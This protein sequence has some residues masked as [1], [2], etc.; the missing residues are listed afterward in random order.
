MYP[1]PAESGTQR[2]SNFLITFV[3]Y[4]DQLSKA[5][6]LSVKSSELLRKLQAA[7]WA[8]DKNRGKGS[9]LVLRHPEHAEPII[10]PSHGS[11]EMATGT[12]AHILKKAGLK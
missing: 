2:V 3:H 11:K 4:Y 5:K 12:A 9:H 10:F 8:A 6:F 7:G 1:K